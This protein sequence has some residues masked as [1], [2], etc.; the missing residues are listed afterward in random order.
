MN[1]KWVDYSVY[2]LAA[3]KEAVGR[4]IETVK[5]WNPKR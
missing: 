4:L 3:D 1:G 2:Y 5:Q